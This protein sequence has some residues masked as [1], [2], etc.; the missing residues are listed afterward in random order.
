MNELDALLAGGLG[1]ADAARLWGQGIPMAPSAPTPPSTPGWWQGFGASAVQSIPELVGRPDWGAALTGV[2]VEQVETW[3]AG[4]PVSSFAS[5]V[6][7][8]IVPY[9]LAARAGSA[10]ASRAIP[11]AWEA[12]GPTSAAGIAKPIA[13]AWKRGA[14]ELLPFEAARVATAAAVGDMGTLD[15]VALS[16]GL[17]LA[18][19]P[20]IPA[21]WKAIQMLRGEEK[22]AIRQLGA[23]IPELGPDMPRQTQLRAVYD[24]QEKGNTDLMPL[25]TQAQEQLE[26]SIRRLHSSTPLGELETGDKKALEKFFK[27]GVKKGEDEQTTATTR[28]LYQADTDGYASPK[29]WQ[30]EIAPL[31]LPKDWLAHSE[32]PRVTEARTAAKAAGFAKDIQGNM[33]PVNKGWY[34]VREV[35]SELYVMA[36]K[37]AGP[38]DDHLPGDKWFTVK[39]SRPDKFVGED[40]VGVRTDRAVKFSQ[41]V[42]AAEDRKVLEEFGPDLQGSVVGMGRAFDRAIPLEKVRK[43]STDNYTRAVQLLDSLKPGAGA[44]LARGGSDIADVFS[45]MKRFVAPAMAQFRKAPLAESTRLRTQARFDSAQAQV[46]AIMFGQHKAEGWEKPLAVLA[47]AKYVPDGMAAVFEKIKDEDMDLITKLLNAEVPAAKIG[48]AIRPL[49]EDVAQRTRVE[50][51]FKTLH[52]LD[53]KINARVTATEKLYQ[54][55]LTDWLEGHYGI[56]HTWAGS[57]R[58]KIVDDRGRLIAVASGR[59]TLELE[60]SAKKLQEV[61]GGKIMPERL[62]GAEADDALVKELMANRK[63][64]GVSLRLGAKPGELANEREGVRGFMGDL[65]PLTKKELFDLLHRNVE[66]KFKHQAELSVKHDLIPDLLEVYSRYGKEVG[67]QLVMR[68]NQMAGRKGSFDRATNEA[69]T[70]VLGKFMGNNAAD[71]LVGAYNQAENHLTLLAFNMAHPALQAVSFIQTVLPKIA[72]FRGA[73]PG[74]W[75]EIMGI[76]PEVS[77]NGNVTGTISVLDPLRMTTVAMKGLVRPDA[78]QRAAL[79]R[80]AN[81]AVIAPRFLEEFIGQKSMFG[82]SVRDAA[83]SGDNPVLKYLKKM[84]E[85]P[86]AKM[87]ELSRAHAFLTGDMLAKKLAPEASQEW[88][89]QFAKQFTFRTMYQYAAADKPRMFAGPIGGT[90]GLFKNWMFH[91]VADWSQYT[92]EAFLKNNWAPLLWAAGGQAALGG[93]ASLPLVSLA[94]GAYKVF[95]NSSAMQDLYENFGS[96][97][98]TDAAYFGLPAFLGVSLQGNASGPFSNPTR[99]INYLFNAA[100]LQRAEKV[101]KFIGYV[102]NQQGLNNNP[103]EMDRTWDLA[104]YALGPRILYKAMAQVEEGALKAIR[105]GAPIIEGIS[106]PETLLN[107]VGLTP[108]KIAK[109]Y[110]LSEELWANREKVRAQSSRLGEAFAQAMTRSDQRTMDFVVSTAVQHGLDLSSILRSATARLRDQALPAIPYD[111]RKDPSAWRGLEV[112][113]LND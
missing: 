68:M 61:F 21:A 51:L 33:I 97:R 63:A 110:E 29:A 25:L 70:K 108:L 5:Q 75:G 16:A 111:F 81:D 95:N 105:N 10:I 102:G 28:L 14:I 82:S 45:L 84:S 7:P 60:K 87:E 1:G 74:R 101:G 71:K 46:N 86:A 2:P 66:M 34:M 54:E 107:A 20:V 109:A 89:Y 57:L 37:I 53:T 22:S 98:W 18:T 35:D 79:A 113:G 93:L 58:R 55:P 106:H 73:P 77:P 8:A 32:L 23:A 62:V 41:Q 50:N 4:N 30:D 90:F 48:E 27:S 9:G 67:D 3:R 47:K 64:A 59:N 96:N 39:T 56:N 36:K 112:L 42:R 49:T 15:D 94:N 80:A 78:S 19:I 92:G 43:L 44:A 17:D 76:M 6:L 83:L 24:L 100:V 40:V 38:V 72:M 13:T 85:F 88:H 52:D 65:E 12:L 91:N 69:V 99:D 26:L 31:A 11:A 104:S 103:F